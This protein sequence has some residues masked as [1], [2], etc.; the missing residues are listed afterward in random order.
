MPLVL[1]MCEKYVSVLEEGWRVRY[2]RKSESDVSSYVLVIRWLWCYYKGSSDVGCVMYEGRLSPLL[3]DVSSY[4]SVSLSL[5]ESVCRCGGCG[6]ESWVCR[7]DAYAQLLYVLPEESMCNILK[8][9]EVEEL[10]GEESSSRLLC[11][12]DWS[13]TEYFWESVPECKRISLETL[14]KWNKRSKLYRKECE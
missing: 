11:M 4:V 9:V 12:Y 13:F 1:R 2:R 10:L 6:V 7:L 8:D 14:E 3:C 5:L